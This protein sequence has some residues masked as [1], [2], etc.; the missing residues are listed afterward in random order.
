MMRE[1]AIADKYLKPLRII[2]SA[3]N[4]DESVLI[5]YRYGQPYKHCYCAEHMEQIERD[6]NIRKRR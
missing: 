5:S 1:S 4:C 2:C 6:A 3:H